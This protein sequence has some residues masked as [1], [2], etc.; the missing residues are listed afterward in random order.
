[1]NQEVAIQYR[2][3][4]KG[5]EV[6]FIPVMEEYGLKLPL[7]AHKRLVFPKNKIEKTLLFEKG[8]TIQNEDFYS[9]CS[10]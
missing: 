5:G 9:F 4:P 7:N 10:I 3:Q 1:M 6:Q 8:K 2:E